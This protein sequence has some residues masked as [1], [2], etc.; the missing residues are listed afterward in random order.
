VPDSATIKS[1]NAV[2]MIISPIVDSNKRWSPRRQR[3]YGKADTGDQ[4]RQG[5]E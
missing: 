4:N 1:A 2:F 5:A 3:Q